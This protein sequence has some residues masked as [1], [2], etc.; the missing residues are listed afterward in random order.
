MSTV[1]VNRITNYLHD[2]PGLA[3]QGQNQPEHQ[4]LTRAEQQPPEHKRLTEL[5]I[6]ISINHMYLAYVTT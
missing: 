4:R 6:P 3:S 5:I 2:V 1:S